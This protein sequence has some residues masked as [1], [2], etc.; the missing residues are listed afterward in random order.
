MVS[1][2]VWPIYTAPKSREGGVNW[3]DSVCSAVKVEVGQ[4]STKS[5]TTRAAAAQGGPP[6][7]LYGTPIA[8]PTQI[9]PSFP[10]VP[11]SSLSEAKQVLRCPHDEDESS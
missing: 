1:V 7:P 2:F 3:T 9:N 10:A 6:K 4:G 5:N 11:K 8:T